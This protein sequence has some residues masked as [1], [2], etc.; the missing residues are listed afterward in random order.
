M[1]ERVGGP[2]G[3]SAP[4][5]TGAPGSPSG[6]VGPYR[7]IGTE[8]AIVTPRCVDVYT[9]VSDLVN[10]D[11][12]N[13]PD[14][15][16]EAIDLIGL[17]MLSPWPFYTNGTIPPGLL[18]IAPPEQFF[19]VELGQ[20]Q[21]VR[22]QWVSLVASLNGWTRQGVYPVPQLGKVRIVESFRGLRVNSIQVANFVQA[23]L[24][25]QARAMCQLHVWHVRPDSVGSLAP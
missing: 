20:P 17:T 1:L 5:G 22:S 25:D 13:F 18:E 9:F 3:F 4:G 7:P 15:A 8:P 24:T 21:A 23:G 2:V 12:L 14:L 11:T 16:G 6:L 19:E 10:V